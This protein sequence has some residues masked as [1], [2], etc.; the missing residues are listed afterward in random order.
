MVSA[1]TTTGAGS[2]AIVVGGGVVV[3]VDVTELFL[4]RP[5]TTLA[6]SGVTSSGL[7]FG[8]FFLS[9]VVVDGVDVMVN[10]VCASSNAVGNSTRV[11]LSE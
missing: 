2:E 1:V 7:L 8:L 11:L 6:I 9:L 4:K 5:L 3:V 10:A